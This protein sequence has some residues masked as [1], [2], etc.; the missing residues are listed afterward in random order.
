MF[1]DHIKGLLWQTS[2]LFIST[3][4]EKEGHLSRP[5]LGFQIS[6][7]KEAKNQACNPEKVPED[8]V[9][10]VKH[11]ETTCLGCLQLLWISYSCLVPWETFE[12]WGFPFTPESTESIGLLSPAAAVFHNIVMFKLLFLNCLRSILEPLLYDKPAANAV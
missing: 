2:F 3:P 4:L 5:E 8:I 9:E 11:C 7:L 10:I 1:K 6:V 12:G